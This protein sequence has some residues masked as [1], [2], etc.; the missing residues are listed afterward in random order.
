MIQENIKCPHCGGNRYKQV[1]N[2]VYKCNYCGS[3]FKVDLQPKMEEEV[4]TPQKEIEHFLIINWRGIFA[5]Y[6]APIDLRVNGI[7]CKHAFL[8]SGFNIKV[9]LECVMNICL[10]CGNMSSSWTFSIDTNYDY[11][12]E[13]DYSK[14]KNW[15][16]SYA[17]YKKGVNGEYVMIRE[18]ELENENPSGKVVRGCA[19]VGLIVCILFLILLLWAYNSISWL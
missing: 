8:G 3:N 2:G 1:S 11:E 12:M 14:L 5:V 18:G 19:I 17:V 15:F 10:S 7:R 4:K 6:D 13:L 16:C 9:P